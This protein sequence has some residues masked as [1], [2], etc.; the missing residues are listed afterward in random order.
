M[1]LRFDQGTILLT[2]PPA[3]VDLAAAPGVRW[4]PRV[5]AHRAPASSYPALKRWLL[6]RGAPGK[7][8]LGGLFGDV[9]VADEPSASTGCPTGDN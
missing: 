5:H 1:D 9:E 3:D 8:L 4:D 7:G 6:P 2:D